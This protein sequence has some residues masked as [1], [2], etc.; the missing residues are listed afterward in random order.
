MIIGFIGL[1]GQGKTL[2]MV[3]S[4]CKALKNNRNVVSNVPVID[5]VFGTQRTATYRADI[6]N[7]VADSSN[8]VIGIDEA[9]I[10]LPNYYWNKMSFDTLVKFAQV[11]KYGLDILYTSQGWNH[12]VK[13]LRDLT[14][15]VVRC[16][17]HGLYFSYTYF[18][19]EFFL[20][21]TPKHFEKDYIIK[22]DIVWKWQ[23]SKL[24]KAYNT[25]H[26]VQ[27]SLLGDKNTKIE[28]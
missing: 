18:D 11:R 5:T 9:S 14:N 20:Q 27:T 13:R 23:F 19:P 28:L 21:K 2:G 10:V 15:Y 7:A 4:M 24:F 1:P 26:I 8:T 22:T 3:Y 6:G 12:T 16:K 25:L 17:N